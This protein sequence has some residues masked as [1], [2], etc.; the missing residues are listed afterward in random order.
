MEYKIENNEE[1]NR[2]EARNKNQVI[3]LIDYRMTASDVMT[4]YHTEVSEDYE[5][6]GI[7]AGMTKNLLEFLKDNGLKVRPLCPYAKAYIEKHPEYQD[8]VE[9]Q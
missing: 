4:V 6:Q 1:A 3:G 8:L 7:A 9:K 2:F 5:G